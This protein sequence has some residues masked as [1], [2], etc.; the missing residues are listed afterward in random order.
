MNTTDPTTKAL[1]IRGL[2]DGMGV[3][4]TS[5]LTGVAKGTVLRILNE[6]GDFCAVLPG[7]RTAEPADQSV[8]KRTK[9]GV[10][11]GPKQRNVKVQ[12]HGDLW[13]FCA[14]D[15]DS[16]LVC[17]W[18]VGARTR[19]EHRPLCGGPRGSRV[20]NKIQLSTD[21]WGPYVR[22]VRRAFAFGR[23]DF[24]TILKELGSALGAGQ[25][26]ARRYSPPVVVGD[27]RIGSSVPPTWILSAPATLS[28]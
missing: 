5:R 21:A 27:T 23:V 1:V 28:D 16:K 18:L 14:I 13:T 11:V 12:G 2:I 8:P 9:S 22:A 6:A 10:F 17:C 15:P 19:R 24:A 20:T 26:P 25:G 3:R 7:P 4:A